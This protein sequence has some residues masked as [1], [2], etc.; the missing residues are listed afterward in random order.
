[1]TVTNKRLLI[2]DSHG[3]SNRCTSC[4]EKTRPT[5]YVRFSH[6]SM[7]ARRTLPTGGPRMWQP[8]ASRQQGWTD[9]LL[10]RKSAP[11]STSQPSW[12]VHGT[13]LSS[14][15][16]IAID[17]V[18]LRQGPI[19]G[20]LLCLP[21]PYHRYAIGAFKTCSWVPT[22]RSLTDTGGGYDT[23]ILKWPQHSPRPSLLSVPLVPLNG[24]V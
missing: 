1:M 16:S 11:D 21:D 3:D 7:Y 20:R 13:R 12:V 14:S 6:Q 10:L 19:D 2:S 17:A 5:L 18:C 23:K 9:A 22:P 4:R 24:P 15:P 8:C